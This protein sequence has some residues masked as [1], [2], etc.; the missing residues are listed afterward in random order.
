M[1]MY[2]QI[3]H[4]CLGSED[5]YSCRFQGSVA[6]GILVF[7]LLI[8][9]DHHGIFPDLVKWSWVAD[10]VEGLGRITL[11]SQSGTERAEPLEA[12]QTTCGHLFL[13]G[14]GIFHKS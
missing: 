9:T 1:F 6:L 2:M 11:L 10:G 13:G 12:F 7:L 4:I 5:E 3:E 14:K 8:Q